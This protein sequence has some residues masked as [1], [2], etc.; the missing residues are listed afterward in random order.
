MGF[1]DEEFRNFARQQGLVKGAEETLRL[2][3]ERFGPTSHDSQ[4]AAE[5]L[6]KSKAAL[7]AMETL[8]QEADDDPA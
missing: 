8:A 2:M 6:G 5:H 3:T 7:E 1:T 4:Q